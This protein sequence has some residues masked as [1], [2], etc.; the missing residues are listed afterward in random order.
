MRLNLA[1]DCSAF[2]IVRTHTLGIRVDSVA[3]TDLR[4]LIEMAAWATGP[5]L[6]TFVNPSSVILAERDQSYRELLEAFDIVLPDGIGLCWAIQ[7]VHGLQAVRISFDTTSLAPL[8]FQFARQERMSIALV[9]GQPGVAAR[10]ADQVLRTF[11]GL[12][13]VATLDGYGDHHAKV[14]ELQ[15]LRPGIVIAGMG[16][17]TQEQF[18]VRL[19]EAGW[20]GLG[21]TCGGYLDQLVQGFLYYPRWIDATNLRWAYRL[22][23]EPS[24]LGYRYAVEYPYF[25]AR[26]ALSLLP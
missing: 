24:R 13:I 5:V 18:L 25:V 23:R 16:A 7:R 1:A 3:L 4:Q 10:A 21:F 15:S 6:F 22:V 14:R 11:P 17:G 20:S 9:G 2:E 12:K 26:L 8:T 19:T